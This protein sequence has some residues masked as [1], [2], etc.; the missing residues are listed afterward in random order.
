[1]RWH[2]LTILW[3]TNLPVL[4]QPLLTVDQAIDLAIKQNPRYASARHDI[5]AADA[6]VGVAAA[7]YYPTINLLANGNSSSNRTNNANNLLLGANNVGGVGGGGGLTQLSVNVQQILLD[8]GKRAEGLRASQKLAEAAEHQSEIVRQ[9]L[10]L[11]VRTRYYQTHTDQETVRIQ[12]GVVQNQER[13]VRESEGFFKAGLQA[14]NEVTKAQ[15]DLAQARLDLVLAQNSLE[16]DWVNLN[17]SMGIPQTSPYSLQ[18]DPPRTGFDPPLARVVEISYQHRPEA[19]NLAAQIEAAT[20]RMEQAYRNRYPTLSAVGQT[21]YRGL[22][23]GSLSD[24]WQVGLN[25]NFVFFNG[26]VDR[27]QAEGFRAQAASLADL[28]ESTRQQVYR[29]AA[30]ALINLRNARAAIETAEVNVRS[31]LE[32]FTL[33]RKRYETGLGSNLEYQDAQLLLARAQIGQIQ[34]LNRY[35][36]AVA[37][38]LRATGI[39]KM[40][41]FQKLVEP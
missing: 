32:N 31:S 3:L 10:V 14:R 11:E 5:E 22:D 23:P 19:R 25:L 27:F 12:Q 28:L 20:A 39:E 36:T 21:G 26:F 13:H 37:A 33:A 6:Q 29:D 41:E 18:V 35:R 34:A 1:M 15:A 30:A 40:D 7:G 38:L 8:F 2:I 16:Q 9:D 4:A 24:Y 17:Q